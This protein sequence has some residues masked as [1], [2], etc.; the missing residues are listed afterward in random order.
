M[1][2]EMAGQ[3][4]YIV[5]AGVSYENPEFG[6][7]AG[8]FYNLKGA[9]LA[10]VGGG[11]YPDVYAQPF[12][13]LNFNLNKSLGPEGRSSITFSVDNILNDVR[14]IDYV[15]YESANQTF[16]SFSPGTTF[17]VGYKFSL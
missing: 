2:Q 16:T 12:H 10:V 15:G 11:L 7:D 5:N 17:S 3:A 14:E 8:F 9:T 13:S 4:P 6:L 1:R